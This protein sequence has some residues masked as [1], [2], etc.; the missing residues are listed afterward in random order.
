MEGAGAA[1]D[2][3]LEEL[4]ELGAS[5]PLSR[6]S[7][8]LLLRGDL[9]GQEEPEETLGEGLL[10]TGGLG[11]EL[12]ALRD[13]YHHVNMRSIEKKETQLNTYGLATEADTLFR[14]QDRSFPDE[15]LY[16]T[17]T[18]I[19]LVKSDLTN[20]LVAMVPIFRSI[21]L[22]IG[23]RRMELAT[24]RGSRYAY[25]RSFLIFSISPGRLSAKVSLRD[26]TIRKPN[27]P[28]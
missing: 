6:E 23:S 2:E 27:Q 12:L 7:T 26:Y 15:G 9:T 1:V 8:D 3:L 24:L 13:L 4:G 5:S 14:V 16:A 21:A 19:G 11:Q 22:A 10:T 20:D 28:P 18:T 25:F 17:G